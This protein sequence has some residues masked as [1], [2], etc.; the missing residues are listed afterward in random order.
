[1]RPL[2][3]HFDNGWNS[4]LAVNN[5]QNT[6]QK[7]G[8][9][10]FTYVVD[11]AEFRDLQRSYFKANVIDI[12][13]LTDHGFMAVLY[14]QARKHQIKYVL[15]G[16]NVVTESILPSDWIYPKGDLGNIFGIQKRFGTIP[17]KKLKSFPTLSP[18]KRRYFDRVLGLEVVS[19]LN[20]VDYRY[21]HVKNTIASELGWRDYG[22]KHYESIFTRFYQGYILPRKFKIDKR[23]AHFSTLICSNQ[24]TRDEAMIAI[25]RPGYSEVQLEADKPFVLKK[26]GFSVE[27]FDD[28]I[29]SP[30]VEH[31]DFGTSKSF[32][33]SYPWIRI[34]RPLVNRVL[35][36]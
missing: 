18:I 36:D 3:V 16:M 7:L 28:Y 15:G 31:S 25:A 21:D 24:M 8:F 30:R 2:V 17:P 35:K 32:Y 10:L 11:W 20:W 34:F 26:L 22:G 23:R 12:E 4:E 27:E 29:A 1:M 13:V 6:V 19:P 5:I 14:Q 9:D 33:E